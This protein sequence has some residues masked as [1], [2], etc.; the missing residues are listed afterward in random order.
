METCIF[1]AIA[2]KQL[3]AAFVLESDSSLAFLD[4]NPISAYHTIVI[5]KAH[6]VNILD[7]PVSVFQ[8]VT[9]LMHQVCQLYQQKLGIDSFQIFNN[10][11]P[12]SAQTVWHLHFHV[13]PRFHGDPIKFTAQRMPE[14]VKQ[15]PEM[16]AKLNE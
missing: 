4:N 15:Y 9:E 8:D 3:P 16:L 11:G 7:V 10:A 5:P 6:H 2:E 13:L 1:C 14:L 12:H